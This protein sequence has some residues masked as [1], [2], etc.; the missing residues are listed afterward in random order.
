MQDPDGNLGCAIILGIVAIILLAGCYID[1]IVNPQVTTIT[2]DSS[3]A[4]MHVQVLS[5]A[6]IFHNAV[7][8]DKK[9]PKGHVETQEEYKLYG[10]EANQTW[11]GALT[12]NKSV[13]YNTSIG[14]WQNW[15]NYN[16]GEG[17]YELR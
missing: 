8:Y 1:S 10:A 12:V 7:I 14:D 5:K 11:G 2:I 17:P 16:G 3:K 6:R 9:Y 4:P 15:D 13:Y